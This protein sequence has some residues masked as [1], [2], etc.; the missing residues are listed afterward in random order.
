M[1]VEEIRGK[2]WCENG[3]YDIF[4]MGMCVLAVHDEP[5]CLRVLKTLLRIV[6]GELLISICH[7]FNAL[8]YL[9]NYLHMGEM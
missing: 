9:S 3:N 1:V 5:S 7:H 6:F 2:S 8:V 4:S